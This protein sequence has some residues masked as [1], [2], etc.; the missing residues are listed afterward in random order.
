MG[1]DAADVGA[2]HPA[3][4]LPLRSQQG[5]WRR[6]TRSTHL[7]ETNDPGRPPCAWGAQARG[8]RQVPGHPYDGDGGV[9][10]PGGPGGGNGVAA[11]PLEGQGHPKPG[12]EEALRQPL[13][14]F[15][16]RIPSGGNL[17]IK[18]SGHPPFGAQIILN[19]H[20]CVTRRAEAEGIRFAKEGKTARRG[21]G[22]RSI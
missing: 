16:S 4:A 15:T 13:P 5:S 10:H 11:H 18:M 1:D 22:A 7:P 12:E 14:V 9:S 3:S 21:R 2:L 17:T 20:D 19:G 6:T 8:R